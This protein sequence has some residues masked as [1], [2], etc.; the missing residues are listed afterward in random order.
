[1]VKQ[2]YHMWMANWQSQQTGRTSRFRINKFG[3]VFSIRLLKE[4]AMTVSTQRS[5]AC[6][7]PVNCR[8][9]LHEDGTFRMSHDLVLSQY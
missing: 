5:E 7:F 3:E 8:E 9:M 6:L 4:G 2:L 1:M